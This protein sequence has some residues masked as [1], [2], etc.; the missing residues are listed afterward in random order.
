MHKIYF[1]SEFLKF[2]Y[3][4][5]IIPKLGSYKIGLNLAITPKNYQK[6]EMLSRNAK[7]MMWN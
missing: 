2:E 4:I 5:P 6:S 1:W 7:K 3:L